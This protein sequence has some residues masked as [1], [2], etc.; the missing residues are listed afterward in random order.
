MENHERIR[1]WLAFKDDMPRNREDG[2]PTIA[3]TRSKQHNDQHPEQT[4]EARILPR[5]CHTTTSDP[6][7]MPV[8]KSRPGT[9]SSRHDR[10][11]TGVEHLRTT[12]ASSQ[13]KRIRLSRWY[14]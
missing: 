11:S 7:P 12:K 13:K 1:C 4:T 8:R 10:Q 14:L 6:H 5:H 9:R 3:A 2:P